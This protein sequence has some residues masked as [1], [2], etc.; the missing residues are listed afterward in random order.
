ML[1]L[2]DRNTGYVTI[3]VD[4]KDEDYD[5]LIKDIIDNCYFADVTIRI[6]KE[7]Q[8]Y[9]ESA[10]WSAAHMKVLKRDVEK[11]KTLIYEIQELKRIMEKEEESDEFV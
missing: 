2:K 4:G 10:F 8:E 5:D 1:M 3:T 6:K 9:L 11:S 7:S